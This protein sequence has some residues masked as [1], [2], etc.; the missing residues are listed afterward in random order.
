MPNRYT[1]EL[2][3]N[4]RDA[5]LLAIRTS[6]SSLNQGAKSELKGIIADIYFSEDSIAAPTITHK[7]RAYKWSAARRKAF[8]EARKKKNAAKK[9]TK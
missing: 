2:N 7:K 1:I 3:K 9:T 4:Q 8:S 6:Y 5:L